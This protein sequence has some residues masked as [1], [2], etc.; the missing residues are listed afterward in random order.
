MKKNMRKTVAIMLS[1]ALF[2]GIFGVMPTATAKTKE[3]ASKKSSRIVEEKTEYSTTY[4]SADGKKETEF[5]SEPIRYREEKNGELIEYDSNLKQSESRK[6][7]FENKSGDK[8]NFIPEILSED[9]PIM[10]E[11]EKYKISTVPNNGNIKG[12]EEGDTVVYKENESKQILYEYKS[13]NQGIKETVYLYKKPDDNRIVSEI[14]LKNCFLGTVDDTSENGISKEIVTVSGSAVTIYDAEQKN[15]VGSL[16]A[17]F[18]EDATGD[19]SSE[20]CHYEIE[21]IKRNKKQNLY[22]Y[23]LA[24]VIEDDYFNRAKLT[25]PL[26]IDPTVTWGD[27]AKI[28]DT[29]VASGEKKTLISARLQCLCVEKYLLKKKCVHTLNLMDCR[30]M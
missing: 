24:L 16:P 5:Y 21:L 1:V 28:Q 23:K 15:I 8:K 12:S 30:S 26:R 25:Y 18:M 19:N 9:T 3:Q 6:G 4:Q 17:G 10:T 14:T 20:E 13:L 2:I 7:Y 11:N 22:T 29:Y 27:K